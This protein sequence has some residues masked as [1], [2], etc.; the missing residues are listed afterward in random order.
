M[1][2]F[3][4][5]KYYNK[6]YYSGHIR[7]LLTDKNGTSVYCNDC[8]NIANGVIKT[9]RYGLTFKIPYCKEHF[10]KI[11]YKHYPSDRVCYFPCIIEIN[12]KYRDK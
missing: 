11:F 7:W 5:F 1:N 10:A 12:D 4:L 3:T 9:K 6:R 8:G 2:I